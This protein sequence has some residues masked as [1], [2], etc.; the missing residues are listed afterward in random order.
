MALQVVMWAIRPPY[1]FRV[2]LDSLYFVGVG[3]VFIVLLVGGFTGAV[4]TL[5]SVLG[6]KMFAEEVAAGR[7]ILADVAAG[8]I[9]GM[10]DQA[11]RPLNIISCPSCS[12]VE[13]EAFIE[14]AERVREATQ[15]AAQQRLTIAVMG[16]RVNG[17]GETDDADLG[18]WCGP[19]H[20]NL[21]SRGEKLGSYG[22]DEILDRLREALD[23]LIAR[24]P[25]A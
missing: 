3:T 17:P 8:R 5:Q 23:G 1:R 12:R 18:L 11:L 16:C 2:Y 10:V 9:R 14:L 19:R 20:V 13:N 15:Y 25:A 6:L 7:Q 21:T 24:P 4:F 22:Y